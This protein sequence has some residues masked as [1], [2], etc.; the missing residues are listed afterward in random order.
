MVTSRTKKLYKAK[1]KLQKHGNPQLKPLKTIQK[2]IRAS[3]LQDFHDWVEASV[4]EME[5]ANTMGDV[6]R[7]YNLVNG[8]SKKPKQPPCNLTT[9]ADGN[10]LRSPEDTAST[11][12]KFLEKKFQATAEE[13]V[14]PPME[15]L[16]K[17]DDQIS[18]EEYDNAVNKLKI[19]KAA[20][21]DGIPAEAYKFCPAVK[22]ELFKLLNFIWRHEVIPDKLTSAK[23]TMLFKHKGSYNDPS[24]YRCIGLLSHAYKAL[25]HI[26][27]GRLVGHSENFLKVWQAGFRA[28]RGCR[29]NTMTL[30]V[31][32]EKM[33]TLGKSLAIVFVDYAAAFDSI[34]HKFI[35]RALKAAGV[36]IKIRA[37]FRVIYQSATAFTTVSSTDGQQ[38]RSD[39]FPIKR[40]VVQGDITPPLYFIL[41][42]ELILRRH[43]DFA[44]KGVPLADAIIHTLA[45]ADDAALA[46][47]GNTQGIQRLT[48][49]VTA[50]SRGSNRDADMFINID[51]TKVLH[52][53][54][55]DP[56]TSTTADEAKKIC[57]FTCPHHNCG[58]KF[59]TKR[60][61]RIHA[62]KCEW[63]NEFEVDRILMFQGPITA[64]R[65][66][67][68]WKNFSEEHDTWEPR[69]NLHPELIKD[70]EI[71]NN[72]YIH[73]WM[74]RCG[75]C[76]LPCASARGI[77]T[78]KRWCQKPDRIQNFKDTLADEAVKLAKMREQQK[79]RPKI[80]CDGNELSNKFRFCYLGSTFTAD[81]QQKHDIKERVAKAMSRCGKLRHVL[82]SPTLCLK[83]KLRLYKAAVCSLITYGC[84]TW[85]L[86]PEVLRR[87]NGANSTMLARFSK[88]TIPQEARPMTTSYNLV[89]AVRVRRLRWLG[90]ILRAGPTQI[91]FQAVVV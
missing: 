71:A 4:S 27:L 32:C 35:D 47:E 12:K 68:R 33:M 34:S 75:N 72:V 55:Q 2:Q 78:H 77:A 37:M 81:A 67:I 49:R 41:A 5:K 15:I 64:R 70:F 20:G 48:D 52:V 25:S 22:D 84:E 73:G 88:K 51:K 63:E 26:I 9:D 14:R 82:D 42:L 13:D 43:D 50:I 7:I 16:P 21:P 90:H 65:Y 24:K 38:V 36:P 74:F 61:M 30:R 59:F 18:R 39:S 17:I 53:L 46:E 10:L 91:T 60:G 87:L 6:R 56:V 11:W 80:Y 31:L 76:D 86:T 58:F 23:F 45:Y 8:L 44:D 1:R 28:L 85:C 79:L 40:G 69:T 54:Q 83:L 19:G 66:K 29:D 89:R 3:C 57:K 62:G